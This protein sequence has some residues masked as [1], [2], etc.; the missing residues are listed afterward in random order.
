MK[1]RV[2]MVGPNRYDPKAEKEALESAIADKPSG[3]LISAA[4]PN[5]LTDDINSALQQGIPVITIDS[6]A[7]SSKR[8]LFVGSD[9]FA[10]GKLGGELLVKLLNGKGSVVMFTYPKQ[11]NLIERQQGYQS[12]FED[13]PEI[14]VTQAVD[15][16]GDPAIAYTTAKQL[17]TS[18]AKVDAFVCLEAIA[19]P[20]VGEV[21]SESN[22]GGKV[23]IMA[24]DTDKRTLKWIQDGL[25]SATIAQKPYTMAY[26]GLQLLDDVHHHMPK[27]LTATYGQ[28]P[29][30]QFP[31]FVD[32]GTFIVDKNNLSKFLQQNGTGESP[33]QKSSV[34]RAPEGFASLRRGIVNSEFRVQR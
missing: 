26:F 31:M 4:D 14:K 5:L 18:K 28:D 34:L 12:V 13:Y 2:E 32:T 7:P 3:I 8:L 15:I 33:P 24:M 9:N 6:D 27:S 23:T 30:A 19:C 1:V 17:L 25:V 21:V 22:I 29:L 11:N 20:E 16:N 10:A